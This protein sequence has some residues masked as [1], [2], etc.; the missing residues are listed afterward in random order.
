MPA[1]G[2]R[3][4]VLAGAGKVF[5]AGADLDWMSK[6][7]GYS[8]DENVRDARGDGARCSRR[9]TRCRF[10][11]IGRVHGAALGGGAGLAAVCDI[12]VAAEDAMFG[13]TEAK[14]GILP[15]VISPF[16]VAQDRRCRRRASCS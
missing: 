5:C 11:S 16:A 9:S 3:V 6:M 2:A 1:S 7:V 4:A 15:A 8:R 12:V 10:R 14:L 13:F